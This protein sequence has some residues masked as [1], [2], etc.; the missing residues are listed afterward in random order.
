MQR[1]SCAFIDG[2][3][4]KKLLLA[5]GCCALLSAAAM[6]A[7]AA[8]DEENACMAELCLGVVADP[9]YGFKNKLPKECNGI[10]NVKGGGFVDG[11]GEFFSIKR[12]L[13]GGFSPSQTAVARQKWLAKCKSGNKRTQGAIIAQFGTLPSAPSGLF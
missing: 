10:T 2:W 3:I 7:V 8:S 12:N 1:W 6:P 4:M 9:I 13:K 11:V 5:A